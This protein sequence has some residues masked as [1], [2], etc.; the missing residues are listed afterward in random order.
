MGNNK[1]NAVHGFMEM[2]RKSWTWARLTD[3]ERKRFEDMMIGNTG[4]AHTC[5]KGGLRCRWEICNGL[6]EA[7]L[8]ALDYKPFGWREEKES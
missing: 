5:I 3:D 7:F 4:M 8:A 2:I 1:D 6:Y